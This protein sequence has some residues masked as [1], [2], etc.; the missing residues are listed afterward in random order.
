MREAEMR[1][2]LNNF[3][4]MSDKQLYE[5]LIRENGEVLRYIFEYKIIEFCGEPEAQ[6]EIRDAFGE[7]AYMRDYEILEIRQS[8]FIDFIKTK[9][10]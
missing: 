8:N 6:K 7:S 10:A 1:D 2:V 3:I 9:D 4:G 5:V